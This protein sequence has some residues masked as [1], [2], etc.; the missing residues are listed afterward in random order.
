MLLPA[1]AFSFSAC[2]KQ[3]EKPLATTLYSPLVAVPLINSN[4]TVKDLL[5]KD[6]KNGT[7][8]VDSNNFL[9]LIYKGTLLSLRADSVIKFPTQSYSYASPSPTV[10]EVTAFNALT[11]GSSYTLPTFSDTVLFN[12]NGT[13][14]LDTVIFKTITNLSLTITSQFPQNATIKVT[15]P[16]AKKNGIPLTQTFKLNYTGTLPI[17]LNT[18]ID[19]SGY[20]FNMTEGGTTHNKF[21]I[22]FSI[23][24]TK[25]F[26]NPISTTDNASFTFA[27]TNPLFEKI[28]GYI[29]Q[30]LLSPH[31]DTVPITIFNNVVPGG[32]KFTI[33]NPSV[34]F[35]L[36]NSYGVPID[37]QFNTLEGYNPGYPPYVITIT[38][39]KLN[40]WH[41]PYPTVSQVGQSV[42]DSATISNATTANT[43]GMAINHTPKNFVYS[44]NAQANPAGRPIA[45]ATNFAL[46]SSRFTVN[47]RLNLPFWG[48]ASN[49][50]LMDT[51]PFSFQANDI[52]AIQSLQ[53]KINATNGFPI[54]MGF[55]LYFTDSISPTQ[56][57]NIVDSL[58]SPYQEILPSAMVDTTIGKVTSAVNTISQYFLD[59]TRINKIANTKHILLKG[60]FVTYNSGKTNVK[61]F[62]TYFIGLKIG[63]MAQLQTHI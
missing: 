37:A 48:T 50:M 62:S 24:L 15:I 9:T 22:D 56:K 46:D 10:A 35:K 29:Q 25:A 58:I 59:K 34:T 13:A 51:V 36:I 4:L 43:L 3:Y 32:G 44:V 45:P 31:F 49:I 33:V 21:N 63:V 28:F 60:T 6:N 40:P 16:S 39:P 12:T 2:I 18:N 61:I 30:P 5:V 1:I 8:T 26:I 42:L 57:Y 23:T 20:T 55:Q 14:D 38:D 41:L 19:V 53:F 17:T 7:I 52:N 54:D 27:F 47:F 11:I